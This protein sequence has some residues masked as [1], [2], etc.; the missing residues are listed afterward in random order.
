MNY[1][2]IYNDL[3]TSRQKLRGTIKRK[4]DGYNKH[5]IIP[6]CMG[7]EDKKEN[8]VLL[9]FRE[10]IIAHQLLH[11]I[12]PESSE[13]T[14]AFLRMIQSSRSDRKENTYKIDKK[15]NKVHYSINSKELEKLRNNSIEYLRKI[16]LGRKQKPESI[17]KMRQK[18]I[19]YK[20]S[21]EIKKAWSEQRKG[22]EVKQE[23]RDKISSSRV[24]IEFSEE[25]K[26]NISK[27][28]KGRKLPKNSIQ[29]AILTQNLKKQV[30]VISTGV[31]YNTVI[32][33]CNSLK[34]TEDVI[35]NNP[36]EYKLFPELKKK[37]QD[38]EGRIFESLRS[39]AKFHKRDKK[40]IKNWIEK[41][42]EKGFKYI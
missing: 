3:C 34:I 6:K 14:Y 9:T 40:T 25:H 39:C 38:N 11:E 17:E 5:H 29:K 18:K 20:Y 27:S 30:E 19:G 7:G 42:P 1:Q 41:H 36:K 26:L 15:G 28:H 16:N 10:H 32:D 35:F 23:T 8:Y 22:H 4:G 2:K 37:I 21:E 31:K 24:G 12:Y 13:L 33:C